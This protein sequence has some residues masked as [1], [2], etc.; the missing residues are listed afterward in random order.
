MMSEIEQN[1][2]TT[3]PEDISPHKELALAARKFLSA[4]ERDPILKLLLLVDPIHAFADAGIHL[5][6][7]ARKLLRRSHPELSY[8]NDELYEG[9]R[10]GSVKLSW[11]EKIELGN[12]R[13]IEKE[14]DIDPTIRKEVEK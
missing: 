4:T 14:Q 1:T 10:S 11:I 7:R 9:V 13:Q 5:S 12:P 3:P 6:K 8:G 2:I